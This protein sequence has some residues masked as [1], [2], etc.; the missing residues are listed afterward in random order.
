MIFKLHSIDFMKIKPSY[1]L[2]TIAGETII[3]KQGTRDLDLTH[4][5][6]LNSSAKFLYENFIGKDFTEGEVAQLLVTTFHI[7][8][9]RAENDAK[10]WVESMKECQVIE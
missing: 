4:I 10:I 9:E 2:R 3:V 5:I 6:S 8:R 1:K 7:S